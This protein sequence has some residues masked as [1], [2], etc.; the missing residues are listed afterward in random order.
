[1]RL[2]KI[3][4]LLALTVLVGASFSNATAKEK[5]KKSKKREQMNR[6]MEEY[7]KTRTASIKK[8]TSYENK[9]DDSSDDSSVNINKNFEPG[10]IA[11]YANMLSGKDKKGGK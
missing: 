10:S 8:A 6:Q 2:I 11:G 9:A 5:T 7:A 1:M 4:I 3:T